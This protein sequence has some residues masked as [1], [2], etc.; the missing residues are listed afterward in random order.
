MNETI[1]IIN[2]VFL[3]WCFFRI[4]FFWW[5]LFCILFFRRCFLFFWWGFFS[6]FFLWRWALASMIRSFWWLL[7]VMFFWWLLFVVFF[8]WA[9]TS[10]V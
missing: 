5:S 8:W 7:F 6:I 2:S 4:F 3:W 10:M 9:L 1:N